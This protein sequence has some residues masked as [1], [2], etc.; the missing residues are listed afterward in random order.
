LKRKLKLKTKGKKYYTNT[1]GNI[2]RVK[3]NPKLS[4]Q[5]ALKKLQRRIN[6]QLPP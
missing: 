4:K 5:L 3:P 6:A 1:H 2:Y